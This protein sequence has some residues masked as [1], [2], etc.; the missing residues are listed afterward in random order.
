MENTN[1]SERTWFCLSIGC[2]TSSGTSPTQS[3]DPWWRTSRRRRKKFEEWYSNNNGGSS[4]HVVLVG[5]LRNSE[6]LPIDRANG[7]GRIGRPPDFE[8]EQCREWGARCGPQ[9]LDPYRVSPG[10]ERLP[11]TITGCHHVGL[12]SWDDLITQ[13]LRNDHEYELSSGR[14]SVQRSLL[15]NTRLDDG[16]YAIPNG[17]AILDFCYHNDGQFSETPIL[18]SSESKATETR[19]STRVTVS[20]QQ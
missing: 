1:R 18:S 20:I 17:P 11:D 3:A 9:C 2:Q 5:A 8:S 19:K 15:R 12:E 16:T 10:T 14:P 7:S 4:T 13:K 6:G